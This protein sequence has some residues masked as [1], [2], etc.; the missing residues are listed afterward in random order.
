M[1]VPHCKNRMSFIQCTVKM[2]C[3]YAL[4]E[5]DTLYTGIV[6][7]SCVQCTVRTRYD[8]YMHKH[9]TARMSCIQCTAK[10][11]WQDEL[12]TPRTVRTRWPLYCTLHCKTE[13]GSMHC[14]KKMSFVH[15]TVRRCAAFTALQEQDDP[16]TPHNKNK[17]RRIHCT[18]KMSCV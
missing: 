3:V 15:Q 10:T 7:M 5:Q 17:I 9:S 2:N 6:W 11:R 4:Q 13:L 16:C 12:C 14:K 18:V 1:C 8:L